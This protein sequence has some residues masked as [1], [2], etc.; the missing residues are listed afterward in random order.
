[1]LSRD[2]ALHPN[3]E[4]IICMLTVNTGSVVTGTP[5]RVGSL[6]EG[7]R[8]EFPQSEY[9]ESVVENLADNGWR[10]KTSSE[11]IQPSLLTREQV[12]VLSHRP[13]ELE[14]IK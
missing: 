9:A 13:F 10:I 3:G 1:M 8:P 6:R 14:R 5:I 11:D 12:K 4:D 2:F 7:E